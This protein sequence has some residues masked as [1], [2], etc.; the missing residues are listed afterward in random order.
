MSFRKS[1]IKPKN[2]DI[3]KLRIIQAMLWYRL[4]KRINENVMMVNIDESSFS[5]DLSNDKGMFKRDQSAEVFNKQYRGTWSLI[6]ETTSEGYY[7]GVVV[8]EWIDSKRYIKFL[9]KLEACL[10][11]KKFTT[12]DNILVLQDN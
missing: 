2:A 3:A 8:S 12:Q 10:S 9:E 5:S 7:F 4:S 11:S 6:L 1:T